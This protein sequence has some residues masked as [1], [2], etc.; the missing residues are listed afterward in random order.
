MNVYRVELMIIDFDS[1]GE[2]IRRTIENARY[3]NRC[4]CPHVVKMESRD[5]GEW[6]DGHPLNML[7]TAVDEFNRIFSEVTP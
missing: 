2:D 6:S 5:I 1:V 7:S 4:I 3:P